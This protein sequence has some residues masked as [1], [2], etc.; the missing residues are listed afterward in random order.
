MFQEIGGFIKIH[1]SRVLEL[2]LTVACARGRI[3]VA[4]A[5]PFKE[6]VVE[7]RLREIPGISDA[8]ADFVAKLH[9]TRRHPELVV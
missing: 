3:L 5:E 9:K 6:I 2:G 1:F 4:I 8:I 7:K